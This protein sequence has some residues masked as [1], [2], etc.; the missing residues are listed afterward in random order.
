MDMYAEAKK[1][2]DKLIGDGIHFTDEGYAELCKF[3][4]NYVKKIMTL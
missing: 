3:I 4:I 2:E 1:Q